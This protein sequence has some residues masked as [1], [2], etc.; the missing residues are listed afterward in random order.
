[1]VLVFIQNAIL[2]DRP[3]SYEDGRVMWGIIGGDYFTIKVLFSY[4]A[5]LSSAKK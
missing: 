3:K 2:N 1:M 4:S 5:V